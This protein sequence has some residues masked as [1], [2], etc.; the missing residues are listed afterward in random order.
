MLRALRRVKL[1]QVNFLL[2]SVDLGKHSALEHWSDWHP[3][4]FETLH[5]PVERVT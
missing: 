3:L 5:R 1:L 2:S 4:A